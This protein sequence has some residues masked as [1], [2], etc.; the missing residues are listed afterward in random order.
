M[1]K[2]RTSISGVAFQEVLM[3]LH[4]H[5]F[6]GVPDESD[7]FTLSKLVREYI[8]FVLACYYQCEHCVTHHERAIERERKLANEK[9]WEWKSDMVR[10][11]LFLRVEKRWISPIEYEQWLKSWEKFAQKLH[12]RHPG[13]PCYIACS[14]GIARDDF[15]MMELAFNS[16]SRTHT[17]KEELVGVIRDIDR[18]V[19]FMKAATSKNRTDPKLMKLLA[20]RE[21]NE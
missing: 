17:E 14:I 20:S 11:L 5:V 19:V 16:I 21:V 9:S 13:L 4:Q 8:A 10:A 18:V 12:K 15:S 1:P 2:K 7:P 6:D 3:E